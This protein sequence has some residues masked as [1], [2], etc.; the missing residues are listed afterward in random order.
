MAFPLLV[1]P[2]CLC[3]VLFVFPRAEASEVKGAREATYAT[4]PLRTS[5][6]LTFSL[7]PPAH[8]PLAALSQSV[9]DRHEQVA[10]KRGRSS[11]SNQQQQLCSSAPGTHRP[12][13]AEPSTS[14]SYQQRLAL[15]AQPA[16]EM[17][18][19]CSPS[20]LPPQSPRR[21]RPCR[22]SAALRALSLNSPAH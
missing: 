4:V 9:L 21:P 16:S 15:A 12:A 3:R 2:F 10:E 22:S 13:P 6:S 19:T 20:L 1:I 5:S 17:P 7:P 14:T 11:A 8:P 18:Q